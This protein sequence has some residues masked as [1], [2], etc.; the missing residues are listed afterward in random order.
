MTTHANFAAFRRKLETGAA[1]ERRE[2]PTPDLKAIAETVEK[3]AKAF[4]DFKAARDKELAEIRKGGVTPETKSELDKI[5]A[6]LDKLSDLKTRLEQVETRN[7]RPGG[8]PLPGEKRTVTPAEREHRNALLNW[9]RDPSNAGKQN[10]LRSKELE[11]RAADTQTGAAGGFAVPEVIAR[12]IMRLG[13]DMTPMRQVA[14]VITAGS[15]DYKELVDVGGATFGWVGETDARAETNTPALAEVA[16]TFGTAYAYP[17]A[18]EESLQDVFFNVEDWLINS[19]AEAIAKGEGA[20]FVSGTGT[21]QPTGFLNGTPVATADA[22]RA[23]GA[24]QFVASGQASAMPTDP[25]VFNSL[26]YSLRATYRANA[27]WMTSK[28][29]LSALRGYKDTTGQFLWQPSL[30]A[31]QP[32][33]FLG[34]PIVEAEDMPAVA[35]NAFPLAFGDFREGYLIVDLAGLRITRDEI[36]TPGYVKFYVRK[37][38]GGKVKNSQA[39][40][41]LKIAA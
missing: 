16:P 22:T 8:D 26:V 37:R 25:Q 24:L 3:T 27:R 38:V 40:K 13:V 4:E 15:P 41:L 31:G 21:K 11:T 28:A 12:E 23:F 18:S 9:M 1:Y 35:A 14:R 39:I 36:T 30:V 29:I 20:A 32:Q 10:E 34:Y 19:S 2:A 17:K 5:N 6:E 7:A 33:T